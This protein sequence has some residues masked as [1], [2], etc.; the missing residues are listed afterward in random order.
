MSARV[1]GTLVLVLGFVALRL[2]ITGSFDRYVKPGMRW[3]LIACGVVLVVLGLATSIWGEEDDAVDEPGPGAPGHGHGDGHGHGGGDGED[4]AD[5]HD[6]RHVPRVGWLLVLPLVVLLLVAPPALGA[7]AA[8]REAVPLPRYQGSTFPPLDA[9]NDGVAPLALTEFVDRALWDDAG[10]LDDQ[11]VRL[12]GLVVHDDEVPGGFLLTRF[13]VSCCA[14]DAFPVQIGVVG[15]G[16]PPQDS[17]VEVEGT[18]VPPPA[19]DPDATE[20]PLLELDATSVRPVDEPA[21][22]YE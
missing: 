22:P 4:A 11:P 18:L 6:H 13:V 2:V 19:L 20:L 21:N 5:A 17:W 15:G 8:S 1:R 3:P 12:I 16:R 10:S 14:A 7:D 9:G